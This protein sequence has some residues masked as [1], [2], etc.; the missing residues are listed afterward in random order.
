MRKAE[1]VH[2]ITFQIRIQQETVV[3]DTGVERGGGAEQMI[4]PESRRDTGTQRTNT[5]SKIRTSKGAHTY[6]GTTHPRTHAR[7]R[8]GAG[9]GAGAKEAATGN[10]DRGKTRTGGAAKREREEEGEKSVR[11]H[12]KT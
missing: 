11:S 12:R 5:R 7:G 9:P 10:N 3:R 1:D 8:R 2:C 6:A 4:H